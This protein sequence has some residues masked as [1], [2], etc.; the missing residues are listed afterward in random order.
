MSDLVL[1]AFEMDCRDWIVLGP[2]EAGLPE[3][4]D[5]AP[6]LAALSSVVIGDD[7][8]AEAC[9]LLTVGLYDLEQAEQ[10]ATRP[11]APGSVARELVDEL[12]EPSTTRFV[13]PAPGLRLAVLAEFVPTRDPDLRRRIEELMASF[14]WQ[15][16]VL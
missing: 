16:A 5:G 15:Q 1:P 2:E 9:G 10:L 4:L 7:D 11:V 8:I 12:P 13:M 14:R 3:D 6:V